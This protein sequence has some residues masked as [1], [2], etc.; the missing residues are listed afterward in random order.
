[1]CSM[2]MSGFSVLNDRLRRP[3]CAVENSPATVFF[4][5]LGSRAHGCVL[6]SHAAS[7]HTLSWFRFCLVE[8]TYTLKNH[9]PRVFVVIA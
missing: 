2:L 8:S 6:C 4:T 9:G 3:R 1:M 7:V 5:P